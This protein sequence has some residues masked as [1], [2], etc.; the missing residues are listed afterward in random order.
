MSKTL[1]FAIFWLILISFKNPFTLGAQAVYHSSDSYN[2]SFPPNGTYRSL[3]IYI[4]IV[5][6]VPSV[7]NLNPD[8]NTSHPYWP[9]S[10][11]EGINLTAISYLDEVFEYVPPS[12]NQPDQ[13]EGIY[14][15]VS[16]GVFQ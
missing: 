6:D 1:C 5:Y 14:S 4:N 12:L 2:S 9:Y 16:R 3:N 15:N 8:A 11:M 13:S 7:A 10:T